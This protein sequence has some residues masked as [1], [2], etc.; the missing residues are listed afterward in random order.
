MSARPSGPGT[1]SSQLRIRSR[2]PTPASCPWRAWVSR[3]ADTEG[4]GS[5]TR[6]LARIPP[7]DALADRWASGLEVDVPRPALVHAHTVYPDGAAAAHLAARLGCPLV[8]TEHASTVGRL[9]ELAE[10]RRIYVA[11]VQ[12]AYR[13]VVV[14]RSLATELSRLMPEIEPV[15]TVIPN[16]V[17]MPA[18]Q[19]VAPGG[20]RPNE[21]LFV[22]HRKASKG[23]STLL[24]ATK[25]ARVRVPGL[26]LRLIGG[27]PT[28]A[29]E[30]GWHKEA[31]RLGIADI[32]TFDGPADRSGVADAMARASVFVH[33]SPRETFGVVAVEALASGLP[34]VASDS[35]GVTEILGPG[36]DELGALVPR[37]RPD[38]LAAAIVTTLNR[39]ADFDPTRLRSFVAER[40]GADVVAER[41]E[42]LY[43]E[44]IG[45][46]RSTDVPT[47]TVRAPRNLHPGT[48][49]ST[50]RPSAPLGSRIVMALDPGRATAIA[51]LVGQSSRRGTTAAPILVTTAAWA[52]PDDVFRRVIRLP[53][54][55]RVSGL[56]DAAA[57][58]SGRTGPRQWLQ[59][60]RHP[61]ALARRRGWLPGFAAS[62]AASGTAAIQSILDGPA[63]RAAGPAFQGPVE[64][65]SCDGVDHL[66]AAGMIDR[67][68]VLPAPGGARWLGDVL[69][70]VSTAELEQERPTGLNQ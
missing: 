64:V 53:S 40:Y 24:L 29:I 19:A 21:L 50:P 31:E 34:V 8:L 37:N 65:V 60:M 15:S 10:I 35:G 48:R 39:R 26:T 67:G 47:G 36:V 56:A 46:E 16:G 25:L 20:R 9:V 30:A 69:S 1:T 7:L 6:S 5:R 14:S 23:I 63:E 55:V 44:A 28:E 27:S 33:P 3:P 59:L 13:L 42:A 12:S 41:L 17:E 52:G 38:A 62:I 66:G 18:F 61:V 49:P 58:R 22:G 68:L 70:S 43:R 11:T 4:R 2:P 45:A 54:S 32:V 51:G 57:L